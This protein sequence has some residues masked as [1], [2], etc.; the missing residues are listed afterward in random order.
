MAGRMIGKLIAG[1]T[2]GGLIGSYYLFRE[3]P[4]PTAE[5][6]A[7]QRLE[8]KSYDQHPNKHFLTKVPETIGIIGGG[9]AGLATAKALNQQGFK[10]EVLEKGTKAGG[11][12]A[13]NYQDAGLQGPFPHFNIPDFPFPEGT[14]L[15][16]KQPEILS[17][18]DSYIEAFHL[19]PLIHLNSEVVQVTQEE[20]GAWTVTLKNGTKKHY[21]FLVLS[22]GQFFSPYIPDIPGMSTFRGLSL[23]SSHVHNAKELFTGKNVV[24]VGG[25]KS[26]Y[27]I[28]SL[29]IAN[30][31]IKP[32]IIMRERIWSLPV[33][34]N[35][36][37]R[38]AMERAT[39]RLSE[40]LNPAPYEP[41]TWPN[42]LL[43]QMG[44]AYWGILCKYFAEGLPD[45]MQPTTDLRKQRNRVIIAR[46][47]EL[48]KKISTGEIGLITG[49]IEKMTKEGIV[50]N[51]KEV[52]AEVVVF[53]TGF[54]R[55]TLG[56]TGHEDVFW[57]YRGVVD[58]RIRNFA[59]VG[60]GNFVFNQL[61]F[62]LQA[63][64]L[65]DVLRGAVSLPSIAVM[66]NEVQSF[67]AAM[68]EA[69]GP[70]ASHNAYA[71]GEMK[72]YDAL[73]RDMH[74]QTRRKRTLYEDLM[75]LPDPLDYKSV[76][77]HRV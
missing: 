62:N 8:K 27:D 21:D 76:L 51:G 24:V 40:I 18:L 33:F 59:V 41:K 54:R 44:S 35:I 70:E 60:Y 65:C 45:F 73:L 68:T 38:I 71:W 75:T 10:V 56:L 1:G 12:W 7:Y 14:A 37:G 67:K 69:F 19:K 57:L 5:G 13:E 43:R 52:P 72:Y 53:A 55:T 61:K 25:S 20:S 50:T 64:W 46:D 63:A 26:A 36:Y 42:W 3:L 11:V 66:K 4:V 77:T 39:C 17:Y 15:F 30:H 6:P 29:V 23:H 74:M 48:F 9:P 58:P 22:T 2:I 47:L 32:T 31:G 49:E 16:P 34:Q 28:L